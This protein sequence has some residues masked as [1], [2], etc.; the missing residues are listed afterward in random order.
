MSIITEVPVLVLFHRQ[1]ITTDPSGGTTWKHVWPLVAFRVLGDIAFRWKF[2]SKS[3]V[4]RTIRLLSSDMIRNDKALVILL[5]SI[6]T[7]T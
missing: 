2:Q 5:L 7:Y 3:H 6:E 4:R 1:W